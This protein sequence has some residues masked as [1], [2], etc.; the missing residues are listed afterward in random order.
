MCQNNFIKNSSGKK[1][2]PAPSLALDPP[3]V[4]HPLAGNL[5]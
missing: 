1:L 5:E 4:G 2:N 3:A